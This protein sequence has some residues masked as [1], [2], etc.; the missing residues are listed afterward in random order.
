MMAGSEKITERIVQQAQQQAQGIL[1]QA[2]A[3][4]A[5]AIARAVHDAEQK[6]EAVIKQAALEAQDSAVRT[7]AVADLTLRKQMLTQ[8]RAVLGEAF[9]KAAHQLSAMEDKQYAELYAKLVLEI[10]Q[11]GSEGIAP[12]MADEKRLGEGFV[13][14]VNNALMQKGLP[15]DVKLLPARSQIAFGCVVVSGGMEVDLSVES[16]LRQT[17]ERCE[18]EVASLL[19]AHLEG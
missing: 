14:S 8:K 5:A 17:R 1:D 16:V 4:A 2:D 9:Q 7:M 6:A 18:G 3:Q 10:V 19:F 12:A 11:K 13:A 15:G